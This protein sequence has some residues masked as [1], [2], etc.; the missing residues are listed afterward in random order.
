MTRQVILWCVEAYFGG[1]LIQLH[2]LWRAQDAPTEQLAIAMGA[3]MGNA[4]VLTLL[5]A[6]LLLAAGAPPGQ[7]AAFVVTLAVLFW[8]V[9]VYATA[10]PEPTLAA[11]R[12]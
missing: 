1:V 7:Q 5:G 4:V 8:A 11:Y 12:G 9:Y 3:R 2:R 6:L 10:R